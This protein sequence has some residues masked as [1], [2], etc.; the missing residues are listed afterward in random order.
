MPSHQDLS[1]KKSRACKDIFNAEI[2][3]TSIAE[4]HCECCITLKPSSSPL[5][6]VVGRP[7]YEA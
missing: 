1:Q 5:F 3:L 4:S 6:A 7:P 2:N